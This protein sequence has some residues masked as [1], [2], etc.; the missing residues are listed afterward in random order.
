M[1]DKD[2]A[3]AAGEEL[4][5]HAREERPSRRKP[6]LNVLP[7]VRRLFPALK[8]FDDATARD[9]IRQA[10]TDAVGH[11]GY[12]LASVGT[13]MAVVCMGSLS[14]ARG[15]WIVGLIVALILLP[16]QA[17]QI[18]LMRREINER[19]ELARCTP[20]VDCSNSAPS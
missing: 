2:R 17:V 12:R 8:Q 11:V 18:W 9:I 20:A 16:A 7:V 5:Q 1:T 15:G 19:C 10:N 13:L 14:A 6:R 4:L 3:I